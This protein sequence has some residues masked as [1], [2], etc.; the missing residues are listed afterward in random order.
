MEIDW[1]LLGVMGVFFVGMLGIGAWASRYQKTAA[2]FYVGAWSAIIGIA[3]FVVDYRRALRLCSIMLSHLLPII[4]TLR[5]VLGRRADLLNEIAALR[6]QVEVLNAQVARPRFRRRDRMLWIW[7]CRLW[8]RWKD[9][10]VISSPRPSFGGT[11]KA[12]VATGDIVLVALL[13]VQE[14]LASTSPSSSASP[15]TTQ[16]GARTGSRSR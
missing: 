13:V 8:P 1:L 7:L 6:H 4:S 15:P 2:D 5:T 10:L 11:A 14:S 3:A 9:V 16:N 12:T